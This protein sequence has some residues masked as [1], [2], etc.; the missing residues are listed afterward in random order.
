MPFDVLL[1]D[2]GGVLVHFAGFEELCRLLPEGSDPAAVRERWI[3]SDSVHRFEMGAIDASTFADRFL[4]EWALDLEPEAFLQAFTA[5]NRGLYPGAGILLER[6]AKSHRL[7]C[8]SNANELHTPVH[9]QRLAPYFERFYFSNE[10]HIAKPS[11]EIF[12][13]VLSDLATPAARIAYFDDTEVNVEAAARSGMI[14]Y[15]TD[16]LAE[17]ERRLVELGLGE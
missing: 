6:L 1:F 9:R 4:A 11:P 16:G 3:R 17:L 12:T 2:L 8:L 13:R 10:I 15:R 7:A 5:W 14:A